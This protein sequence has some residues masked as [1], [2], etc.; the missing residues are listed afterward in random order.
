MGDDGP[1]EQFRRLPPSPPV[2]S[3]SPGANSRHARNSSDSTD[4]VP[5]LVH[6]L[7]L[8]LSLRGEEPERRCFRS[9]STQTQ[10]LCDESMD[11][12]Q[13]HLL[14]RS[15]TITKLTRMEGLCKDTSRKTRAN[16]TTFNTT[17]TRPVPNTGTVGVS[18]ALY[19]HPV[20]YENWPSGLGINKDSLEHSLNKESM[21]R[22]LCEPL[23]SANEATPFPLSFPTI[24]SQEFRNHSLFSVVDTTAEE[25]RHSAVSLWP[26]MH[27]S[28]PILPTIQA[29]VSDKVNLDQMLGVPVKRGFDGGNQLTPVLGSFNPAREESTCKQG[30]NPLQFQWSG[31]LAPTQFDEAQIFAKQNLQN[32]YLTASTSCPA[33]I[34]RAFPTGLL[35]QMK[36]SILQG[37]NSRTGPSTQ[38]KPRS[39]RLTPIGRPPPARNPTASLAQGGKA[40]IKREKA[41]GTSVPKF[42]T[43]LKNIPTLTP[44]P[45]TKRVS[46]VR[47]LTVSLN[48]IVCFRNE[49]EPVSRIEGKQ[50]PNDVLLCLPLHKTPKLRI[51]VSQH[52]ETQPHDTR[53]LSL[54]GGPLSLTWSEPTSSRR[55]PKSGQ[56]GTMQTSMLSLK[57][58]VKYPYPCF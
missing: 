32:M 45:S 11:E 57:Q 22:P 9:D 55:G 34:A 25:R 52:L 48:A 20:K 21:N 35:P 38:K 41:Q 27:E 8:S 6:S 24:V 28:V 23:F 56:W 15:S 19:N 54:V 3:R 49:S 13:H 40:S 26:I 58:M 17:W 37:A 47:I 18:S 1:N 14:D 16:Q 33:P 5:L 12:D 46:R 7:P 39:G 36:Q 4:Q 31:G 50:R 44:A 42:T 10:F 30:L 43:R 2:Q 53:E 51:V 29:P